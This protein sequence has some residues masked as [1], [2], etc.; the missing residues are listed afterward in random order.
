MAEIAKEEESAR[1]SGK[2]RKKRW[3][4]EYEENLY[5]S[6]QIG[7]AVGNALEDALGRGENLF[8][9]LRDEFKRTLIRMAADAAAQIGKAIMQGISSSAG[10]GGGGFW[11]FLGAFSSL[12]ATYSRGADSVLAASLQVT[13]AGV[14][15]RD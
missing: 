14:T 12:E 6:R 7:D 11:N 2:K 9:A 8:K 4:K 15:S 10:G 13:T 3:Q 1:K 5:Y